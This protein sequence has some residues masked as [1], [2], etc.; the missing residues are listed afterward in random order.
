MNPRVAVTLVT[1]NSARH[2]EL[3]LRSLAA[4][5]LAELDVRLWDNASTDET[6][7]IAE[8]HGDLLSRIHAAP[9][10]VGF[11]AAQ[12]RLI[13]E[14]A[15][16]YV[17]VLN[18]DVVLEPDFIERL[19]AALDRDASAGS[20]T[21]RLYRWPVDAAARI[22]DT[23]GIYLTANQRHLDR[24]SGEPDDGRYDRPEYVFGASGAAAFYRRAMLEDV[25][26]GGEYFDESFFAYREDADLAW[27][28]QWLGWNCLYVPEARGYHVRR[29]LPERRPS[30]PGEINL[31]SFKNRF[32]LR[33]KNMDA[34]T[35]LRFFLPITVRDVAAFGYVLLRERSSLPAVAL[36]LRELPRAWARRRDLRRRRR[37]SPAQVRAW[38]TS[39]TR[40]RPVPE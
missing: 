5:T 11:C 14:T 26:A 19:A 40:G 10:N 34:G 1:W 4:Q 37:S 7:A 32:L 30:L 29:V 8:R 24:G 36:V 28:A 12:N 6:L 3:C 20:A 35:Y 39:G 9:R 16:D 21:G 38:F 13:G 25:R 22:L 2:L 15:T 23:T 17:L 33:I 27:R 31:H 18:P